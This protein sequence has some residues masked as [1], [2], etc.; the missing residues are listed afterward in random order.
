MVTHQDCQDAKDLSKAAY[1]LNL[2]T[3]IIMGWVQL[4]HLHEDVMYSF[5]TESTK[6]VHDNTSYM[7]K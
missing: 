2:H 3:Y 5:V 1:G 4:N 7:I 6:Q